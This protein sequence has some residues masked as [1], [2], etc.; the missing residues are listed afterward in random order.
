MKEITAADQL[1]IL[2]VITKA[3]A[4]ATR[5]DVVSYVELFTPEGKIIGAKGNAK[6][7]QELTSFTK[8]TWQ[9]EPET[10]FHLTIAPLIVGQTEAAVQTQSTLLLVD[11]ATNKIINTRQIKQTLVFTNKWLISSRE[12]K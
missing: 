4:L 1:A 10:T 8:A 9:K 2:A 12:V 7:K 3:D 6:G 5:R 11:G